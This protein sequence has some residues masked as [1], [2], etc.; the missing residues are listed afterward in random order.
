MASAAS[1][2]ERQPEAQE[3]AAR[4][5][6]AIQDEILLMVQLLLDKPTNELFGATEFDVR[7]LLHRAGAKVYQLH[8]AQKKM[9][10]SA[11]ASPAPTVSKPPSSRA[12]ARKRR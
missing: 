9:A 4:V 11:P 2:P 1:S 7:D 12:T 5:H 8:L 10:T 3:L 6:E